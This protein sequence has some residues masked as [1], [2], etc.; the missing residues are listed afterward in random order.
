MEF[1]NNPYYT[2]ITES[3]NF[4]VVSAFAVILKKN[5]I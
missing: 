1:K 5:E 2:H 4:Y 3:E